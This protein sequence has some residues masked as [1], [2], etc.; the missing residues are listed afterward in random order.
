M[1]DVVPLPQ[2]HPRTHHAGL[3]EAEARAEE[4][5]CL[6]ALRELA[7]FSVEEW[8]ARL[9]QALGRRISANMVRDWED[10]QGPKPQAQWSRVACKMAYRV[11]GQPVADVV[12]RLLSA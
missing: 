9:S 4:A 1:N 2:A 12:L 10:P 11:A 7:G 3:S 6:Q 8:A 5:A